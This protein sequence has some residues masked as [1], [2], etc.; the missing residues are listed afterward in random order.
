MIECIHLHCSSDTLTFFLFL[1]FLGTT[2]ISA[3]NIYTAP[4]STLANYKKE[5]VVKVSNT[6]S[7][8]GG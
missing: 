2:I 7:L 5:Y 8:L 4:A 1:F 6:S 3:C